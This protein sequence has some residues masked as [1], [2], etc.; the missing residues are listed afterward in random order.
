MC[1]D[2]GEKRTK[3]SMFPS[4]A[5]SCL[6]ARANIQIILKNNVKILNMEQGESGSTGQQ[7]MISQR[8]KWECMVSRCELNY[9]V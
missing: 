8:E 7:G 6:G 5:C 1:T 9:S 4:K 2:G 3:V